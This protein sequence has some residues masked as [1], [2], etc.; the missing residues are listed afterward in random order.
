VG[1]PGNLAAME[2]IVVGI[3]G[4]DT[5]KEAARQAVQLAAAMGA[6]VHF[7]TVVEKD[8]AAVVGAGSDQWE[9]HSIDAARSEVQRF[10]DGLGTPVPFEVVAAEGDPA[11]VLINEAE[12]IDADLIVVGNVRMQGLGRLLGSVGNHVAHHAPCSVLIVKTV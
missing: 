5:A 1:S 10:V 6:T 4:G 2:R 3:G 11:K 8:E 9:I 7:V 12:R